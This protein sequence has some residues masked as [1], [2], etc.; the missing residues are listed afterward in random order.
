MSSHAAA[1]TDSP[2]TAAAVCGEWTRR[3]SSNNPTPAADVHAALQYASRRG[4]PRGR[5]NQRQQLHGACVQQILHGTCACSLPS[6]LLRLHASSVHINVPLPRAAPN[7]YTAVHNT[8]R[9]SA[10]ACRPSTALSRPWQQ[11]VVAS[12]AAH[13]C[14]AGSGKQAG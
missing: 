14:I 13:A 12:R 11:A 3:I 5:C 1:A 7:T 2:H 4:T 9:A 10:P 6:V 8:Q